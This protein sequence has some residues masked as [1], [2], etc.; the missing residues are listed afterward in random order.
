[1]EEARRLG[2][3][4]DGFCI[5]AVN[6]GSCDMTLHLNGF[7]VF[8]LGDGEGRSGLNSRRQKQKKHFVFSTWPSSDMGIMLTNSPRSDIQLVPN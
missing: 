6:T 1:M 7:A 8:G 4:C 2:F 5:I 3:L